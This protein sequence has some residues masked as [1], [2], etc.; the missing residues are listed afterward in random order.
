MQTINRTISP[1]FKTVEKIEMI[2]ATEKRLRNNIPVYSINAGT[3]ELIKV[4]F[5][6]SAGMFQQIKPLQA[7]TVNAMIEE[8]TSKMN[9]A[10]IADAVDYYGAFLEVGVSQDHASVVSVSYTHLRAHET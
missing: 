2:H 10:Q 5:I 3:Q 9:A 8:G 1:A 4:E 7:A 6:F